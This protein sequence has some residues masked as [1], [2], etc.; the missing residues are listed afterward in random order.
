MTIEALHYQFK[1]NMD[2]VDSLSNVDFNPAEIDW[3]LNEAQ[4]VFIHQ[5]LNPSSNSK[6]V[7]FEETQKRTDDLST[8]V[9]QSPL[10][11]PIIPSLDQGVYEVSTDK[12]ILPYLHLVSATADV[13]ISPACIKRVRLKFMQHDDS[14]EVLKDPFNSPSL[15]FIPY[16]FGRSSSSP[17]VPS[18]Y[19]YPND[20][21]ILRVYPEYIKYPSK[22]YLG[23]YLDE[24]GM[25]H[26]PTTLELPSH[27]HQ[28]IV[29]IA[30]TIAALNTQSPSYIQLKN[31]KTQIHE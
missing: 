28:E 9:I 7:G 2:R 23:T 26:P 10:Q 16:N 5:R 29:D 22:P 12:C 25:A 30:C 8:L 20:L 13:Q 18:I 14:K 6:Q 19:I 15:E 27:T 11:P 1:L 17:G 4:M 31:I 3:L 21:K 24:S